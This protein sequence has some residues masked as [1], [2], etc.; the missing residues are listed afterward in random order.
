MERTGPASS[1]RGSQRSCRSSPQAL[2]SPF[3]VLGIALV[4]EEVGKGAQLVFRY[5]SA[6]PPLPAPAG[7]APAGPGGPP[8]VSGDGSGGGEEGPKPQPPQQQQPWSGSGASALFFSLTDRA[9]AKL[10]RP[11]P[12]LCGQPMTLSVGGTVFCCRAV[13]RSS[14][15]GGGTAAGG[16]GGAGGGGSPPAGSEQAGETSEGAESRSP[17]LVLFSVIVALSPV[18]SFARTFR[19][20][21]AGSPPLEG[22]GGT[23][24]PS[25]GGRRYRERGGGGGTDGLGSA[26]FLAVRRVHITLS[27]L[28]R[29]LERE[30]RRRGY[31]SSQAAAFL[32]IKK[33]F[34]AG[35][36]SGDAVSSP[37][38]A[39]GGVGGSGA[40]KKST[41]NHAA[42]GVGSV[43]SS[44]APSVGPSV[45]RARH[46]R[47]G[48]T[49][50]FTSIPSAPLS[51]HRADRGVTTASIIT[52]PD[53][54]GPGASSGGPDW[55]MEELDAEWKQQRRQEEGRQAI[56]ELMFAYSP[57]DVDG[58]SGQGG[59]SSA[60]QPRGNLARELAQV[61]SALSRNDGNAVLFQ[62]PTSLLSSRDGLVYVN[63][64]L[65]VPIEPVSGFSNAANSFE[66]SMLGWK[67]GRTRRHPH[68]LDAAMA[69]PRSIVRPYHTLLFPHASPAELVRAMSTD[70]SRMDGF[71]PDITA[72]AI[73]SAPNS[74]HNQ[75]LERLLLMANPSKSLA[76][77][78]AD[79][80][81][82]VPLTLE[83]AS[84]LV[85]SGVCSLSWP[86]SRSIRYAVSTDGINKLR[87]LALAF[88]QRFGRAV[89]IFVA[90]SL[91]TS[92]GKTLGEVLSSVSLGTDGFGLAHRISSLR[93]EGRR[94]SGR[95]TDRTFKGGSSSIGIGRPRGN[96]VGSESLVTP[97]ASGPGIGG[98][99]GDSA[100]R[101]GP[102]FDGFDISADE[103]E[104]IIYEMSLWLRSHSVIVEVREYLCNIKR[105]SNPATPVLPRL[106]KEEGNAGHADGSKAPTSTQAKMEF[107]GQKRQQERA[108]TSNQDELLYRDL[109]EENDECFCGNISTVALCW[110]YGLDTW[111]LKKFKEWC[112]N[113]GNVEVVHRIPYTGDD[114]G[115]S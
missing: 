34:D 72:A 22:G 30:E 106:F 80:V 112:V 114:W 29:V 13:L 69:L 43:S 9:M 82:S 7:V 95:P 66:G 5:P 33:A 19:E 18:G 77:I 67:N 36:S 55:T 83:L 26:S 14:S 12:P 97:S 111:R 76:D 35:Q 27:R 25:P 10:F 57:S 100:E 37:D 58:R 88:A 54:A 11:K 49:A 110:K 56:I 60:Q 45:A 81:L 4:A 24:L 70:R 93:L 47:A 85:E 6:P 64:H 59:G 39:G 91:L 2:D 89:P 79:A 1:P 87:S 86:M 16:R 50:T 3:R 109:L 42:G 108:T 17:R 31:V 32:R 90:V 52:V 102:G 53:M 38:G 46:H 94:E 41:E 61:F 40:P 99:R 44:A 28:C 84:Y 8:I 96:S 103:L 115:A 78:A 107:G 63:C 48:S 15:S 71:L 98:I 21:G 104:D 74:S 101:A 68:S 20:Q 65:A 23:S 75:R 92:K 73:V 113:E 105:S 51:L 62:T